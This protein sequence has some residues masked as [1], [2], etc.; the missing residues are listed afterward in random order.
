MPHHCGLLALWPP[1]QDADPDEEPPPLPIETVILAH[2][3]AYVRTVCDVPPVNP[4]PELNSTV[5]MLCRKLLAEAREQGLHIVWVKVR[6]HSEAVPGK[7]ART[8]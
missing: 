6:G 4:P 3:S 7:P 5:V 8:S 1:I 2:D